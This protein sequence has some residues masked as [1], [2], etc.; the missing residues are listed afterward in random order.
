M[1]LST[2]ALFFAGA[3]VSS[4]NDIQLYVAGGDSGVE[5]YLEARVI[6][7]TES[8]FFVNQDGPGDTFTM[9]E[10]GHVV[11]AA[12]R[13]MSVGFSH[14]FFGAFSN[15]PAKPLHFLE[16]ALT[17]YYFFVCP[18]VGPQDL[19]YWIV[20]F[21]D[22]PELPN[23]GCFPI[24]VFSSGPK[25]PNPSGWSNTTTVHETATKTVTVCDHGACYITC[26]WPECVP[27]VPTITKVATVTTCQEAS[28]EPTS[29][30]T[31]TVSIDG[32]LVTL[33][34]G[35][36]S[37]AGQPKTTSA[38][39]PTKK[40]A[41]DDDDED[42]FDDEDDDMDMGDFDFDDEDD[43]PPARKPSAPAAKVTPAKVTPA[44]VNPTTVAAASAKPSAVSPASIYEGS[45]ASVHIA[46]M[47]ALLGLFAVFA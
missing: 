44:K 33:T 12:H 42:D 47:A 26:V 35:P 34:E 9:T 28:C 5:G 24:N 46:G 6:S 31:I 36:K 4:A 11:D 17:D 22:S 19:K 32:G 21:N 25:T 16:M 27:A 10:E 15:Q 1:K 18:F 39:V 38:P 43:F 20:A 37:V 45:G 14:G 3:A 7:E 41:F 29:T 13:S 8:Y 2:L 23:I 30:V 40:P